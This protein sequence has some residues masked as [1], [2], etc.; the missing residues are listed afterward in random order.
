MQALFSIFLQ[1]RAK[2]KTRGPIKY[3]TKWVRTPFTQEFSL[4]ILN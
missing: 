1:K 3:V 2:L 4:S